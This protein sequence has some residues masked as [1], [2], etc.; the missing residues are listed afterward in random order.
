MSSLRSLALPLLALGL[1]VPASGCKTTRVKGDLTAPTYAAQGR[2]TL[3]PNKTGN[4][5][6]DLDLTHLAPPSRIEGATA[7]YVGWI[8]PDGKPAVKLGVVKI[9]EKRRKGELHGTTPEKSFR[10]TLTL[11]KNRNVDAPA[12]TVIF[13]KNVKAN[14]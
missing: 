14:F 8:T 5:Q 12:G 9:N 10:F 1:L 3:K 7:G 6:L 2:L 4:G 13:D 11:E